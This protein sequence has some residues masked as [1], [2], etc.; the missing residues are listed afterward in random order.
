M[1]AQSPKR[2]IMLI[3]ALACTWLVAAFLVMPLQ[4][5]DPYCSQDPSQQPRDW[6]Q[7]SEIYGTITDLSTNEANND[8]FVFVRVNEIL[9]RTDSNGAYSLKGVQ[10]GAYEI[11]LQLPDGYS[12]AESSQIVVIKDNEH[13]QLD[14]QYYSEPPPTENDIPSAT[15][16]SQTELS[17]FKKYQQ[18]K[19]QYE[20]AITT[21]KQILSRL[22][23]SAHLIQ[24]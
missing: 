14:L 10:P 8:I 21:F 16:E 2:I 23:K 7:Y 17:P 18:V 24:Q 4:A 19:L 12:S 22:L 3:F 6:S 9:L 5:C 1:G 11:S 20:D 13:V 15:D